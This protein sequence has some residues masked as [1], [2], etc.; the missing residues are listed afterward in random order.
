MP[1]SP[2]VRSVLVVDDHPVVRRG[3][4]NLLSDHADMRVVGEAASEGEALEVFEKKEPDLVVVDWSLKQSDSQ[5]LITELLRRKPELAILV[6]SIHDETTHADQAIRVGAR[7]YLMKHEAAHKILEGSRTVLDGCPYFSP[8][9]LEHISEVSRNRIYPSQSGKGTSSFPPTDPEVFRVDHSVSVVVPVFNSESTLPR[10][11]A[12]LME[13]LRFVR[14]LQIVLVDDGSSDASAE[15]CTEMHFRY[16]N[17]VEFIELSHNS[18]EHSALLAGIRQVRGDYCVLMDDDLQN[19]PS[20]I[21][22]LLRQ[23]ALGFDAVYAT[24][25]PRRHAWH[26]KWASA[27]HNLMAVWVLGKPKNLYL[28]SFKALSRGVVRDLS[29]YRGPKPYIDALILRATA[30]ISTVE[31]MHHDRA[32]GRSG[33]TFTKLLELWSRMLFGFSTFPIRFCLLF[34]IAAVSLAFATIAEPIASLLSYELKAGAWSLLGFSLL[35]WLAILGEYVARLYQLLLGVRPFII[36][37][38][39]KR[40]ES[41]KRPTC[42]RTR[43]SS[44]A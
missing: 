22:R 40:S 6:V 30:N 2:L 10:L 4:I 18:G 26:R 3:I 44:A 43:H 9:A 19:P 5:G 38:S 34:L 11:C 7:G 32:G 28:S 21:A 1:P 33:Y 41:G 12:E 27:I 25:R 36:R 35:L 17:T 24:Y 14:D 37:R 13:N 15:V 42:A 16:P 8:S 29:K 39:L 23:I 31:C 20:E